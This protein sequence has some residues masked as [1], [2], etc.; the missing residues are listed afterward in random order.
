MSKTKPKPI[1]W[2]RAIELYELHLR[3]RRSSERTVTGYLLEVHYLRDHFSKRPTPPLPAAVTI[4]DLRD[5]QA[6]LL[7]GETTRSGKPLAATSAARVTAQLAAFFSFLTAEELCERD[8][9]LR[10]ERP[11]VPR[12][13]PG[14]V[15]SLKEVERI[16]EA[17]DRTTPLG[18]RDLA[19]FELL[20]ATGLRRNELLALDLSDLDHLEREVRVRS[21]KGEKE[22][23]VPLTRSAF[24]AVMD[25]LE[26]A[27]PGL[28]K[29]HEDSFHALFLGTSGRR[30]DETG[31]KRLLRRLVSAAGIKKR[32]TPHTLRRTFATHLMKSGAS[33]RHIQLLLGHESLDTTAIYLRLD[34]SEL[35]REVV[36]KHPR[37]RIAP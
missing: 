27:R 18:L 37:E 29:R 34:T 33:L 14:S 1:T 22:R 10:L 20:Y 16:L 31:I 21:G 3:A 30:L 24:H 11:K 26:R 2:E 25:Y 4:H 6:G 19:V 32:T 12:R 35:R 9:T 36:T 13:L 17:T 7:T 15:L 8:P 28:V 23:I 5:Y